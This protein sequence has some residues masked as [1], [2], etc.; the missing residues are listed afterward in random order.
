MDANSKA[1]QSQGNMVDDPVLTEDHLSAI[2]QEDKYT[3]VKSES[4][5]DDELADALDSDPDATPQPRPRKRKG[6]AASP[7]GPSKVPKSKASS[8]LGSKA[9]GGGAGQAWTSPDMARFFDA[10]E[11]H[12]TN[13]TNVV[14]IEWKRS[15]SKI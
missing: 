5:E 4:D 15:S 9:A 12:G 10:V 1:Q 11:K 8:S 2:H 7:R 6:F 14:P 13:W 3:E